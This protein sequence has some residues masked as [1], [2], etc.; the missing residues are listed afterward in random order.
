[1]VVGVGKAA[2]VE[3][4]GPPLVLLSVVCGGFCAG[5][6]VLNHAMMEGVRRVVVVLASEGKRAT[7]IHAPAEEQVVERLLVL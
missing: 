2:G 3:L 5:A 4:L 1:M 7:D 6:R